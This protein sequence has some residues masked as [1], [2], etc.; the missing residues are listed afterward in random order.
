MQQIF[1]HSHFRISPRQ[2]AFIGRVPVF[3]GLTLGLFSCDHLE[4][5]VLDILSACDANETPEFTALTSGV[6]N[7]L[8]EDFTA[9][10][11]GNCPPAGLELK[12]LEE[13]YPGRVVP[14]SIHAGELAN[15]NEQFPIDW[16]CDEGNQFWDDIASNLNPVGRVNRLPEESTFLSVAQ[17]SEE[18]E[19]LID[20]PAVAGLQLEVDYDDI[21][22][23]ATIHSHVTW[24][25]GLEG[26][27]R[28][29]LLIVENNIVAPQLWY[30]QA[31][32][33]GPGFV[34]NFNHE[35][36]L[37]GSVTGAKGLVVADSP[38]AGDADQFCYA[39]DWE[40]SWDANHSEIIAVLTRDNGSVIQVLSAHVAE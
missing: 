23:E 20:N 28:L 2:I 18:V 32:P 29:A 10:Q 38:N 8:V 37:R 12:A 39:F 24:F 40:D 17:W 35:H 21:S 4:N 1:G 30:P 14:L 7:I 36:V 26:A 3:L 22:R 19:A 27:V 25:I 15:T 9:H 33:S 5:P 13:E 11:C 6:Q 31:N 34:E 16:R